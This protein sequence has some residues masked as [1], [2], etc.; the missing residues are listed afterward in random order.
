MKVQEGAAA[1]KASQQEIVTKSMPVFYNPVMK[2]NRDIS[3]L[4]LQA[5]PQKGM[6]IA[7][8]MAGSGIRSIRFLKELPKEKIKLLAINDYDKGSVRAIRDNL[9][10]NTIPLKSKKIKISQMD[11]NLF[12]LSS[13]GFDYIDIDPFGTP[14]P[15][16]D[17]AVKRLSRQGILA[18]TATDTA[19]LAGTSPKA[20]LRKYWAQP[21]RNELKHEAGIRILIRKVQLIGAQFEKALVPVCSYAKEHYMRVFFS[22]T[23]GKKTVDGVF[24]QHGMM[25]AGG[26]LWRGKLWDSSLVKKME[27][28]A[29]ADIKKFISLLKQEAEIPA[30]GFFDVH[31]ECSRLKLTPP[32]TDALLGKIHALGFSA[33]PTHFS[34]TGIR[35]DIPKERFIRLLRA[36]TRQASAH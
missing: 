30:A 1:I 24:K 27:S 8:P 20:C 11:T 6:R 15:F 13:F 34:P 3:V 4:L 5:I 28:L 10:M 26:P 14:N 9:S 32:K 18:V 22:C 29:D 12:L 23:K 16:L 19:A 36:A 17:A 2:L 25:G 35:T 31:K 33:S 7:D 21:L